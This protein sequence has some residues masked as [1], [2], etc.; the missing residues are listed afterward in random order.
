MATMTMIKALNTGLRHILEED[1]KAL[2]MGE[3][4]GRLGGVFRVTDALQK[5]FGAER[6]IDTPLSESG[7]IGT[8]IGLALRGYRSEEHTSALQS[9]ENLVCRLLLEKNK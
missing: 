3:D 9:R 1:D 6:V 2:I 8:A 4:D 7:I 5:D